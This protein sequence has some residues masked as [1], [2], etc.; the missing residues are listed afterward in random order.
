MC[1]QDLPLANREIVS[2]FA[3]ALDAED[4]S[5]A[6]DLLAEGCVY[7]APKDTVLTGPDAI[8][9]SYRGN[10]DRARDRFDTIRYSHEVRQDDEETFTIA[11]R[12]ELTQAGRSHTFTCCQVAHCRAGQ[13]DKIIHQELPEQ[14]EA[15]DAF[16]RN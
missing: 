2:R 14:R 10:G 12:D 3:S 8:I 7:H 16:L 5:A 15:L 11:Y 4:Y 1:K 9:A 13:I 6:H